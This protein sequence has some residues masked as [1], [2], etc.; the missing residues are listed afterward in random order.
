MLSSLRTRLRV[1]AAVCGAVVLTAGLTA[2]GGS[3]NDSGGSSG[4]AGPSTAPALNIGYAGAAPPSFDPHNGA[5][6]SFQAIFPAYDTLLHVDADGNLQPWL[7]TSWTFV[8]PTTLELK[9][10]DGVK[11]TDGTAFDAAAV[12]ANLEYARDIQQG[13]GYQTFL[14]AITDVQV[15]D[16]TTVHIM[17]A[18]ANPGL[19]FDLSQNPGEMVSPKALASPD[20]LTAAPAGTGPYVLDTDATKQGTTLA[21]KR[22]PDYWGTS[23]NEFPYD[24]VVYTFGQ[25]PTAIRNLAQA[26]SIDLLDLLP[27]DAVPAGFDTVNSTS[28]PNAGF[29]GIWLDVT[30]TNEAA[31]SDVRV[32]QAMNYAIDRKT[33]AETVYE[34]AATP[35]ATVPITEDSPAYS[36]ELADL[37]PFDQAKAKQLLSEAGYGSGFS[38]KMLALPVAETF[39]QAIAANLRDVGIDA[40]I[41]SVAGP[42]LPKELF[43][44]VYSAGLLL[45]RPTG[46]PGQDLAALFS[47]NAFYNVHKAADPKL[48]Q[49]LSAANALTDEA[50]QNKAFQEA[51]VYA[52]GQSWFAGT[53]LAQQI[54]AFK[55]DVV[56]VTPPPFGEIFLYHY[57]TP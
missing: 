49:M 1:A 41:N 35:V 36:D 42:D 38:I 25:D 17:L 22:N 47:P 26:G 37:Y 56:K 15:V 20:Q 29:T 8:N 55:T 27:G 46:Q 13:T 21:W 43:S 33:I 16:P 28:G 52:A 51:A 48:D 11:F 14:K 12:K 24:T 54:S 5:T 34:G 2:C 31:L 18:A 50:A 4:S 32:R 10:R 39:A 3:S 19:P 30:G 57:S 23:Q 45:Q 44:G 6:G 40:Q 53:L 7:A 9:L